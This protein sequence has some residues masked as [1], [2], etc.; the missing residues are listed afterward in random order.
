MTID[1]L[2]AEI[3]RQATRTDLWLHD[4][5]VPITQRAPCICIRE[6]ALR[7]ALAPL[8]DVVRAAKAACDWY[9]Y[10]D[11]GVLAELHAALSA[12]PPQEPK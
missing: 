4:D 12:I 10:W 7:E 3:K 2:M 11:I 8:C 1:N 6:D 9:S 5:F